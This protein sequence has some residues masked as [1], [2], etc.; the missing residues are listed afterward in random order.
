MERRQLQS[1]GTIENLIDL[2]APRSRTP[3]TFAAPWKVCAAGQGVPGDDE[4]EMMRPRRRI[5]ERF[6][7]PVLYREGRAVGWLDL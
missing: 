5:L 3:E 7:R 4:L 6:A 2:V 1:L